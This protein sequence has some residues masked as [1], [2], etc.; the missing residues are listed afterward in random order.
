A[1]ARLR[2]LRSWSDASGAALPIA[3]RSSACARGAVNAAAVP[4]ATT[5]MTALMRGTLLT[6]RRRAPRRAA[7]VG[8]RQMTAGRAAAAV[9]GLRVADRHLPV[10]ERHRLAQV[11]RHR[12]RV[13]FVTGAARAPLL[14]AVDVQEVQV[15]IAVAEA[16]DGRRPLDPGE[17]RLVAGE[18]QLVVL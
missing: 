15:Q 14:G 16:G 9:G 13:R 2:P 5:S 7:A 11:L 6:S 1:S 17:I 8:L 10:A 4:S 18:A 3:G 12:A